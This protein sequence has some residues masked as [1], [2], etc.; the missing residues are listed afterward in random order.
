MHIQDIALVYSS[1]ALFERIIVRMYF[2]WIQHRVWKVIILKRIVFDSCTAGMV[3]ISV[4]L[5]GL[6][7]ASCAQ[8][9]SLTH[10]LSI[11]S[12]LV[13]C[14]I[15]GRYRGIQFDPLS[16]PYDLWMF[17][18]EADEFILLLLLERCWEMSS[19]NEITA[20]KLITSFPEDFVKHNKMFVSC[21]HPSG[22][23]F[24]SSNYNPVEMWSYGCQ[25]GT[26]LWF[27]TQSPNN[28]TVSR[29]GEDAIFFKVEKS[30]TLS[31]IS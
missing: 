9:L 18:R 21:V 27:R 5:A 4:H 31:K 10:C 13:S 6:E 28:Y 20:R 2:N 30:E 3:E 14:R 11:L 26:K 16:I 25:M 19:V 22:D 8:S 15:K 23:R 7:N 29:W 12:P 17:H 1:T 24:D